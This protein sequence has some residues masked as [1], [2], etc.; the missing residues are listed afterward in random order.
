MT[1]SIPSK[2]RQR[3]C[4]EHSQ[5][6]RTVGFAIG[7]PQIALGGC[8]L[9]R[10]DDFR[11]FRHIKTMTKASSLHIENEAPVSPQACSCHM[12]GVSSKRDL[13]QDEPFHKLSVY[14]M[15][16]SENRSLCGYPVLQCEEN[17]IT[18][19]PLVEFTGIK[20][21]PKTKHPQ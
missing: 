4:Q 5:Q 8:E 17:R 2:N 20:G 21:A 10:D 9:R 19:H 7:A 6:P 12:C 18:D 13:Y 1:T 16:M 14:C 15:Y 11:K 3:A